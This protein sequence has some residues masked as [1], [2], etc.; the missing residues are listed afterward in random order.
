MAFRIGVTQHDKNQ[1][2]G[3]LEK[4]ELVFSYNNS[5]DTWMTEN[6]MKSMMTMLDLYINDLEDKERTL[7]FKHG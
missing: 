1:L 2:F 3:N 5:L 7:F 6:D 4:P